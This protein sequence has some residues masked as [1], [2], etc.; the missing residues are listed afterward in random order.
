[1]E[2]IT[3]FENFEKAFENLTPT[4]KADILMGAM[5]LK[6]VKRRAEEMPL[7]ILTYS[8]SKDKESLKELLDQFKKD[9]EFEREFNEKCYVLEFSDEKLYQLKEKDIKAGYEALKA[10]HQI[11]EI[12][13]GEEDD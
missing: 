2:N 4:E 5:R 13:E 3:K 7:K 9:L 1:M 8:M 6:A 11:L 10:G 12:I